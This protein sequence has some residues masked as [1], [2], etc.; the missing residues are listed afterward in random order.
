M[1][2]ALAAVM[3]GV[4]ANA[5]RHLFDN[6]TDPFELAEA[7]IFVTT[8][9]LAPL[10]WAASSRPGARLIRPT[11]FWLGAVIALVIAAYHLAILNLPVAV[12]ISS[13]TPIPPW[14]WL[15]RHSGPGGSRP[16]G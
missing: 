8:L 2:V 7:R 13:S 11:V 9:G 15:G 3:W 14:W 12:A 6:G 1:A 4:A 16:W 10:I 5:S